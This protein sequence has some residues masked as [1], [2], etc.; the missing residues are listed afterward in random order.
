[1]QSRRSVIGLAASTVITSTAGCTSGVP[2]LGDE[3]IE[4]DAEF[5]AVSQSGLDET[6]YEGRRRAEVV[7]EETVEAGDQSQ[8]VVVTN[9]QAEYDKTIDLGDFGL[10]VDETHE[11]AVFSGLTTPQVD[12]LGRSFNPV[13]NKSSA[14]LAEMV[15]E[16]YEGVNDLEQVGE[17]SGTV[18]GESTTVGELEGAATLTRADV[19]V[20]LT[21]HIAEAVESGNDLIVA[22]GGYPTVLREDE[23]PDVFAMMEALEHPVTDH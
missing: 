5:A 17:E 18:A 6:G 22:V 1:M 20:D 9:W 15:Q 12:V 14:E 8:D 21:L 11:A 10:P 13:A 4:F 16:H 2:F 3:P 7:I 19:S 23:R